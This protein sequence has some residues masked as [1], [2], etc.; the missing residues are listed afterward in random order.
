MK[1]LPN[2]WD[3]R[4]TAGCAYCG[5]ATQTRD[6]VPSKV[7]LDKPYPENL[8]V[9]PACRDCNESFSLDEEYVACLIECVVSGNTSPTYIERSNIRT[10]LSNKPALAARL[11]L[12]YEASPGYNSLLQ[13]ERRLQQLLLK[14]ARG[15]V[16]Y[17]LNEP[18]YEAPAFL[19]YAPLVALS[20]EA[21]IQFEEVEALD[22]LPEVGSRGMMRDLLIPYD[23]GDCYIP[24][25]L[26]VQP[27]R[28]RYLTFVKQ[29]VVVRIVL[30]EYLACEVVWK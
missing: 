22:V 11:K 6:H 7:L 2:L 3:E 21:R 5:R 25:W 29:G 9:V 26:V 8:P 27:D 19:G 15:H 4:Q 17:E 10:I 24:Q 13:E 23:L 28:Y 12:A 18:H 1:Q 30:S 14:L 16:L 20:D